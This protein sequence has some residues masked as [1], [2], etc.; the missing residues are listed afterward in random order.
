M[1][2][3]VRDSQQRHL[4]EVKAAVVGDVLHH[5]LL[6]ANGYA[7]YLSRG[8]AQRRLL[9]R[10]DTFTSTWTQF[11]ILICKGVRWWRI[12]C[13]LA[14]PQGSYSQ[15]ISWAGSQS[16]SKNGSAG[17]SSS[18][19]SK[20]LGLC[21]RQGQVFCSNG[22]W[23]ETWLYKGKCLWSLIWCEYVH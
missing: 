11:S 20:S 21:S 14:N 22:R 19:C 4:N 3:N 23:S 15:L 2:H 18:R 1:E 17:W 12:R 7:W 16:T 6:H 5:P 13:D 9:S 8:E 10:D